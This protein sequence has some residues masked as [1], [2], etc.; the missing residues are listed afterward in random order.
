MLRKT[1]ARGKNESQ[2]IF[3]IFKSSFHFCCNW[4]GVIPGNCTTPTFTNDKRTILGPPQQTLGPTL[5]GGRPYFLEKV[6]P[7][8]PLSVHDFPRPIKKKACYS[9]SIRL[10]NY[11][12]PPRAQGT[13]PHKMEGH[14][15]HLVIYIYRL[16]FVNKWDALWPAKGIHCGHG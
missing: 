9:R 13:E 7:T 5:M 11:P 15:G 3:F 8:T 16:G 12:K 1:W 10:A 4:V 6:S 14:F 2:V